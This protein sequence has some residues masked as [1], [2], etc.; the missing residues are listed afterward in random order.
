MITA[1]T[2][3]INNVYSCM[4]TCKNICKR[5]DREKM[6]LP[7]LGGPGMNMAVD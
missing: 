2:E 4:Y 3:N 6:M 1:T 5:E 7:P